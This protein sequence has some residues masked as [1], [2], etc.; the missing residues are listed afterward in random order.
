MTIT[1]EFKETT[2]KTRTTRLPL[3][4]STMEKSVVVAET[5]L[6]IDIGVGPG[7]FLYP[8]RHPH[9][10]EE[11]TS[12]ASEILQAVRWLKEQMPIGVRVGLTSEATP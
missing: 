8:S 3:S 2:T 10:L 4:K 6:D 11:A 7:V 12:Y 1:P 9:T 5:N